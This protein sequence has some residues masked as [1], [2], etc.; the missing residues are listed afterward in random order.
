M[1]NEDNSVIT[2]CFKNTETMNDWYSNIKQFKDGCKN[3]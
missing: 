2:L 1:N 3:K